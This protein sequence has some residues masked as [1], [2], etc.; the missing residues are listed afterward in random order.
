[1]AKKRVKVQAE[2]AKPI[3]EQPK[4]R[5]VVKK[6]TRKTKS[7]VIPEVKPIEKKVDDKKIPS[8]NRF[9]RH[10]AFGYLPKRTEVIEKVKQGLLRWAFYAVDNDNG[11]HYYLKI[12]K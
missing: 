8:D 12:K 9:E 5:P 10:K 1:M 11:Y 7:E 6:T 2:P 3:V 4:V